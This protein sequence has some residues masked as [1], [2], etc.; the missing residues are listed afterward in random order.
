MWLSFLRQKKRDQEWR[1]NLVEEGN[2]LLRHDNLEEAERVLHKVKLSQEIQAQNALFSKKR[3][4][5]PLCI[6]IV[7]FLLIIPGPDPRIHL[8]LEIKAVVLRLAAEKDF[9]WQISPALK[10][11][12]LYMDGNFTV[13]S[14]EIGLAET[15]ERLLVDGTYLY[16]TQ[17]T[18]SK[19]ARL[20]IEH[21]KDGV[22]LYIY[23][24][25]AQGRFELN[26]SE[27]H[28]K[29]NGKRKSYIVESSPVSTSFVFSS[30]NGNGHRL[31]LRFQTSQTW[32]VYGLQVTSMRFQQEVPPGSG[33]FVS[34]IRKGTIKL[35]ETKREE[36]LMKYDELH[37]G[38]AISS[39]LHLD[40][41]TGENVNFKLLYQ[42]EAA[43]IEIRQGD[44]EQD[45][46]P[47]SLVWIYHQKQLILV[48]GALTFVYGLLS[49]LRALFARR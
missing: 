9:I 45:L 26:N 25:R 21:S 29:C 22:S 43:S 23:E 16:L 2:L 18:V 36:I 4:I 5:A 41:S 11:D 27:V 34:S 40:F 39:R 49:N 20:E 24:G 37:V 44:F 19:G 42:G 28:L 31:H 46:K 3:F 15:S 13:E 8:D 33:H 35:P 30:L 6:L 38:K 12:E 48:W 17:L 47:S 1:K 7:C 14:S 10:I 32:Q